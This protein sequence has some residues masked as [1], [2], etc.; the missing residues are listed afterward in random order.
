MHFVLRNIA[1]FKRHF[2]ACLKHFFRDYT[3]FDLHN[4]RNEHLC[5]FKFLSS[6][7]CG[8]FWWHCGLDHDPRLCCGNHYI[9]CFERSD[10]FRRLYSQNRCCVRRVVFYNP[11]KRLHR[12]HLCEP[13]LD[14][15]HNH[16]HIQRYLG[17]H[18]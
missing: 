3:D 14:S 16:F 13:L 8:S 6:I 15:F 12:I 2:P 9:C 4:K 18:R 5:L 7:S 17:W 10:R 11:N 1:R